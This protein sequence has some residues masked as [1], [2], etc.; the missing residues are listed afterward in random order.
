MGL[1]CKFKLNVPPAATVAGSWPRP[2]TA[3]DA[4]ETLTCEI[5]TEAEPEFTTEICALAVCPTVTEPKS[6]LPG[7]TW[8]LPVVFAEKV[9]VPVQPERAIGIQQEKSR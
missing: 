4:P 2:L 3:K 8:T 7:D 6:I 5:W 9:T 1:N